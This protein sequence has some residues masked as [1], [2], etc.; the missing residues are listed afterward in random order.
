M[1]TEKNYNNCAD[2]QTGDHV[3]RFL[4]LSIRNI[5][6]NYNSIAQIKGFDFFLSFR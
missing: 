1:K 5:F 6:Q 2:A 4:K 3:S